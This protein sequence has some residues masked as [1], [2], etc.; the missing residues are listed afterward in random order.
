MVVG[1]SKL[2]GVQNSTSAYFHIE[3]TFHIISKI[4]KFLFYLLFAI[5]LNN[6]WDSDS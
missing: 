2:S 3:S 5:N 6:D 4:Y 1:S